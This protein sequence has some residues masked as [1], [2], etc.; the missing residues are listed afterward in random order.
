M[1]QPYSQDPITPGRPRT[2]EHSQTSE[3]TQTSERIETRNPV[4]DPALDTPAKRSISGM[5]WAALIA[6]V[7]ILILLLVFIIQNNVSTRFEYMAWQFHLPLG[8]AMLLSAIA[9]ALIMAL[10][11]SVRMFKL[12]HRMRRLERE[13]SRIQDTLNG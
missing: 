13:R 12:G 2:P 11:G 1:S 8:A 5:V 9:G 4:T 6:G 7:I 10:A 3:R